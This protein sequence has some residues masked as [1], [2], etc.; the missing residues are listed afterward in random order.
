MLIMP[1]EKLFSGILMAALC[2]TTFRD[3]VIL[4]PPILCVTHR[5]LIEHLIQ[6]FELGVQI[7]LEFIHKPA[8][9][10]LNGLLVKN[11]CFQIS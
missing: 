7:L 11:S 1:Y 5:G 6:L 8:S 3:H 2:P 9:L 4:H 10:G